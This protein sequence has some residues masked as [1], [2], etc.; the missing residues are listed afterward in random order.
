[1]FSV[2]ELQ[3]GKVN[4]IEKEV[5]DLIIDLHEGTQADISLKQSDHNSRLLKTTLIKNSSPMNL[6]GSEIKLYVR[7][8]N[9]EIIC[10]DAYDVE[11][12]SGIAHFSFTR[13]TLSSL[14]SID[15]EVVKLGSDGSV[16]SFPIFKINIIDSIHDEAYEILEDEE[17]ELPILHFKE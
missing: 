1:M 14:P 11:E 13:K 10:L 9:G 6:Y 4:E 3:I 12:S 15:C 2:N 5:I 7:K 16:L 8:S 17:I